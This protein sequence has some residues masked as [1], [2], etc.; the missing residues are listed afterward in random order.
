MDV[1]RDRLDRRVL[2]HSFIAL[3]DGTHPCHIKHVSLLWANDRATP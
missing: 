2:R 1:C 3:S